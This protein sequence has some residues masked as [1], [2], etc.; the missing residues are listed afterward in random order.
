[1]LEIGPTVVAVANEIAQELA[2]AGHLDVK[3]G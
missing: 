2:L 3:G 1:M